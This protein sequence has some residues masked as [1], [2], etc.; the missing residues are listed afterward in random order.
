M[1]CAVV[2]TTL[3]PFL[4][5]HNER[6]PNFSLRPEDLDRRVNV[7]N[8]W[9]TGLLEMINGRNG[10]SVSGSDR[11]TI[12]EAITAIM[13]RPEW[14]VSPSTSPSRSPKPSL[15]SRST[16]S[17]RSTISDF[18]T[19]SVIHNI[20][21]TY[22]QN[23]LAQMAFVVNKLSVRNVPASVVA[24]CGKAIAYAF[25]YCDG[26]AEILVRLWSVSPD[27]LRRVCEASGISRATSI[28]SVSEKVCMRF[29]TCVQKLAFR[30]IR[31]TMRYLRNRPHVP[32]AT[33]YIPWEGPWTGR[34]TGRDTDLFYMFT[35]QYYDLL[36]QHLPE[37]A[38]KEETF[39][40]PGYALLQAQVLSL[41]DSTILRTNSQPLAESLK[42]P[43]FDDLFAEADASAA[44][45]PMSPN[46][47]IR[48]MAENR[49]IMLLRDCLSANAT[50]APR[51]KTVFAETF[52]GLMKAAAS[53]T[54]QF[55]HLACFTLCD[56]LEEAIVIIIRFD[57]SSDPTLGTF[58]WPFWIMVCRLMMASNNS[59]TEI[60]LCTLLY[61]LWNTI[62]SDEQRRKDVCLGWLL[63][64]DTFGR[65]FN[66]WCPMVRAYYMRLLIWR[67]GRLDG[68]ASE[69]DSEILHILSLRLQRVWRNY[70]YVKDEAEYSGSSLPTTAPCS[71]A[72]SRCLLIIRNEAPT[73]PM[74]LSFDSILQPSQPNG[75]Q[76]DSHRQSVLFSPPSPPARKSNGS[77]K[78]GSGGKRRWGLLKN[79]LPFTNSP[80]KQ[81]VTHPTASKSSSVAGGDTN[82]PLSRSD[83][84]ASR[85]SVLRHNLPEGAATASR[86]PQAIAQYRTHSFKFSLEW[87]ERGQLPNRDKRL[88]P[89]KLPLQAQLYL[90]SENLEPLDN[91]PLKPQGVVVNE[92]RYAGR[93][94]AEWA[95]LV[96]ECHNF[97]ERR[98]QEGVPDNSKVETPTLSVEPFRKP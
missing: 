83:T 94:L 88:Y 31:S 47:M 52:Q 4:K 92:T 15:K 67:I 85:Q 9:W 95:L 93:A 17:L 11:P 16:T 63:S 65:Q 73:P 41:M 45:L 25:F 66:H 43:S 21:N 82:L 68:T 80:T 24:F 57:Q 56:F 70:L 90:R 54:S 87:L 13:V 75:F 78:S 32:I 79:I 39:C 60:R 23:L 71:P 27:T 14:S 22:V 69:V 89:P 7:L 62:N 49:L 30:N 37:N 98:K 48:S 64:E 44:V 59:M 72:P 76:R 8:R 10:E 2:R 51:A 18:L 42:G 36:S 35:K 29:P 97:F 96:A 33:T 26:V 61:S 19:E 77:G 34:W 50:I 40:A 1:K 86:P 81:S 91:T 28:L 55:D 12:L 84:S 3:L 53:R 46:T 74:F 5:N 38:S 58:D 20:R 6:L